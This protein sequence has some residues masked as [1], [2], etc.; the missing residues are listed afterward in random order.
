MSEKH[1]DLNAL[2]ILRYP[3]PR[4]R[5]HVRGIPE[6]D[7]FLNE[8]EA[9]MRELMEQEEGI[10]LA[11]TQVGWPFRFILVNPTGEPGDIH[12]F[13]NPEIVKKE[14][15]IIAE[16]GC[17]SVPGIFAKVKRAEAITVRATLINGEDVEFDVEGLTA[18]VFQHELDHLDG[19]LFVDRVGP[20]AKIMISGKLKNLESEFNGDKS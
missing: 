8:M 2:H 16:E 4:L 18:R 9:R 20:T 17:L 19:S 15:K 13:I 12:A 6:L 1:P 5:D 14:G 10:G 11:A 3:D 7:S